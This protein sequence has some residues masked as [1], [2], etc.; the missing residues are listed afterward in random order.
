VKLKRKFKAV[1]D[2][3]RRGRILLA[4][5]RYRKERLL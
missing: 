5:E 4:I 3:V 1:R 2:L